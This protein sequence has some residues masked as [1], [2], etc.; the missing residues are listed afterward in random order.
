MNELGKF[1]CLTYIITLVYTRDLLFIQNI[2]LNI[3][4]LLM[5]YKKKEGYI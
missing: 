3:T 5:K 1:I 4:S 2:Y